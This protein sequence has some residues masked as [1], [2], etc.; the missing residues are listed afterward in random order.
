[1][2][3]LCSFMTMFAKNTNTSSW[4]AGTTAGG[5]PEYAGTFQHDGSFTLH[6]DILYAILFD[7][8][9]STGSLYR[10]PALYPT[11][12]SQGNFFWNRDNDNKLYM[13]VQVPLSG[14]FR[15][16]MHLQA[17]RATGADW[18]AQGRALL[19][20]LPPVAG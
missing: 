18:V 4:V 19:A 5:E 6:R 12:G 7:A 10:Y 20:S 3:L 17:F 11:R 16:A 9:T 1:M 14:A 13:Q 8:S 2:L 15:Y